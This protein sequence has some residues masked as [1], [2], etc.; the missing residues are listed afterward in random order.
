MRLDARN[1]GN[2]DSFFQKVSYLS[3]FALD[4][5]R[6]QRD[7]DNIRERNE[8]FRRR[9][10]VV[11]NAALLRFCYRI[12]VSFD[13]V[14]GVSLFFE[15]HRLRAADNAQTYDCDDLFLFRHFISSYFPLSI[16]FTAIT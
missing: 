5:L 12:V 15:R 11:R 4:L 10:R 6:V 1:V 3:E 2:D 8:S 7:N 13:A 9:S 16:I 14:H